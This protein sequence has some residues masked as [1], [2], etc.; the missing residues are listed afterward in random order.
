MPEIEPQASQETS[1]QHSWQDEAASARTLVEKVLISLTDYIVVVDSDARITFINERA[2]EVLGRPATEL[3]GQSFWDLL[4]GPEDEAL[5]QRV[6]HAWLEQQDTVFEYYHPRLGRWFESRVYATPSG[7]VVLA[8]DITARRAAQDAREFL[9]ELTGLIS[10]LS[11]PDAVIYTAAAALARHLGVPECQF[12]TVVQTA[13]SR[14]TLQPVG[15]VGDRQCGISS[16]PVAQLITNELYTTLAVGEPALIA[17]LELVLGRERQSIDEGQSL[18][19][20]YLLAPYLLEGRWQALLAVA[21]DEPRAWRSEE[22]A[23]VDAVLRRVWPLVERAR[24]Q[25]ELR[26]NEENYRALFEHA[27]DAIFIANDD[28]IYVDANAAACLLSGY[29]RRELIGMSIND[30]TPPEDLPQLDVDRN[31]LLHASVEH[32]AQIGEWR[33]LRKDGSRLPVEVSARRLP[34]GRWQAFVRDNSERKRIEKNRQLLSQLSVQIRLLADADALLNTTVQMLG[35]HLQVTRCHIAEIDL[36]NQRYGAHYFWGEQ[37]SDRSGDYDLK[38]IFSAQFVQEASQGHTIVIENVFTD[39]RTVDQAA[40]YHQLGTDAFITVPIVRNGEWVAALGLASQSRRSWGEDEIAL[41]ETVAT[42][43]WPAV[44]RERS[45]DALRESEQ[46][47]R[48]LNAMLERLV[49]ERTAELQRRNRDLDQFAY[50]ASHDLKAPLRS[51]QHLADWIAQDAA[52][53]L[54]APSK[55]HLEKLQSR[56]KRMDALLDDLL[57]YSRAVRERHLPEEVDIGALVR[58][59]VEWHGPPAGFVVSIDDPLPALT[60][61]RVALATILRNLI[62]NAVKHHDRPHQGKVHVAVRQSNDS[63]VFSVADNGPG[64]DPT[65]HRRIFDMFQTLQP[66]DQVEGSGIGLTVVKNLVETRGGKIWLESSVGH[67][68]TFYFSW[69]HVPT[70][71]PTS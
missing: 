37:A 19:R 9:A 41:A 7:L 6:R 26:R 49:E 50:V 32:Q 44:E 63:V 18:L 27:S 39:P 3:V 71:P 51:V 45:L 30:L 65:F 64:I 13:D 11:E 59:V 10:L 40:L 33:L 2:T 68:A 25:A 23:V 42:W 55:V 8:T 1:D 36:T 29:S 58:E 56:V 21:G 20:C 52:E 15:G 46:R 16:A 66:R 14:Y 60:T 12:C 67:G 34:D 62:G 69:P 54:P 31:R 43:V 61:E 24:V 57:H 48:S 17:D 35:H 5:L 28:R 47:Y 70:T 4:G 38:T 22:V 53:Q